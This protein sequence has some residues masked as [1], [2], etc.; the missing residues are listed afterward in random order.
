MLKFAAS[1]SENAREAHTHYLLHMNMR[2]RS[3]KVIVV[4]AVFL[5]SGLM[6]SMNDGCMSLV[7]LTTKF[8]KAKICSGDGCVLEIEKDKS[9]RAR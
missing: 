3:C 8:R 1:R 9:R 6:C 7:I 5:F 4:S 2:E